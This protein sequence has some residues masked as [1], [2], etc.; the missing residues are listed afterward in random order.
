MFAILLRLRGSLQAVSV[1]VGGSDRNLIALARKTRMV[2]SGGRSVYRTSYK[3]FNADTFRN[4]VKDLQQPIGCQ[5]N[6][7][8]V[9]LENFLDKLVKLVDSLQKMS[10]KGSSA[11]WLDSDSDSSKMYCSVPQE[12]CL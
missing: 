12:S 4:D 10:V 8:N 7:V 1:A 9:A 5:G 6:G 2:T 11:P 3:R